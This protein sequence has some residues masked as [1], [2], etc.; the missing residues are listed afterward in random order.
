[1]C[2]CVCVCVCV[3]A[4]ESRCLKISQSLTPIVCNKS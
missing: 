4:L 3:Y 2:V 1:M